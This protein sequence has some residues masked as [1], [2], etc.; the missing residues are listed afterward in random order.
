M[1][2]LRHYPRNL[3]VT[4]YAHKV[5]TVK[6]DGSPSVWAR[7]VSAAASDLPRGQLPVPSPPDLL[8]PAPLDPT[9]RARGPRGG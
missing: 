7:R 4:L 8:R 6:G 1:Y 9:Q 2:I 3:C 5:T